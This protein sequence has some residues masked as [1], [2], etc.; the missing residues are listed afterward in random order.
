M[1]TNIALIGFMGTGKSA[2]GR[3]LAQKLN[4]KFIETDL[5]IERQA[6]KPIPDIFQQDGEIAFRELEIEVTKEIARMER[7]VIACGGGIIL[8]KINTDRLRKSSRIVYLTA[9]P[10]S[11]LKRVLKE[12]GQRPLL[13]VDN[14]L[15][16]ITELLKFRKPFYEQAADISVNTSKLDIKAVAEQIIE[17]LKKDESFDLSK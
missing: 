6:G 4:R 5:L 16:T 8:N 2:V 15:Q 11:I 17:Q 9:S 10:G 7:V 1:K 3:L 12:A 13:A 14:P